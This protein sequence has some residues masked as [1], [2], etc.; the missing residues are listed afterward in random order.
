MQLYSMVSQDLIIEMKSQREY[1]YGETL[2]LFK[3][4]SASYFRLYSFNRFRSES[5]VRE[6]VSKSILNTSNPYYTKHWIRYDVPSDMD[7]S[8]DIDLE[9]FKKCWDEFWED[10][11]NI[12]IYEAAASFEPEDTLYLKPTQAAYRMKSPQVFNVNNWV[13]YYRTLLDVF[14]PEYMFSKQLSSSKVRRYVKPLGMNLS[15]CLEYDEKAAKHNFEIGSFTNFPFILTLVR[16]TLD[17]KVKWDDYRLGEHHS[18]I[19][20]LSSIGHPLIGSLFSIENMFLHKLYG[21]QPMSTLILPQ[22]EYLD[23]GQAKIATNPSV[24][25]EFCKRLAYYHTATLSYY[26]LKYLNFIEKC[27]LTVVQNYV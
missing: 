13:K 12:Q 11:K 4:S 26:S 15:L 2:R 1:F 24:D 10:A 22:I 20:T 8:E 18:D 25:W 6:L 27:L 21:G 5:F 9:L 14:F 3:E 19:I 17:A 16:D 7:I 23:N